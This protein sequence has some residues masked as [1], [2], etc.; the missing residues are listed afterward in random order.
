MESLWQLKKIVTGGQT[1]V[2]RAVLD[3][4]L[5]LGIA[6]GGFCPR[7]R[8]AEDG[9]ISQRYPLEETPSAEYSERTEWNVRHSDATLVLTPEAP[10]GGT[11]LTVEWAERL[12]RPVLVVEPESQQREKVIAWLTHHRP[13]VLNIAGPRESIAPGIYTDT[14]GFLMALF[15]SEIVCG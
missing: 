11:L 14:V 10:T 7:G 4:A 9:V 3:V 1:G 2:D 15:R 12:K 8:L 5:E 13:G 6:V